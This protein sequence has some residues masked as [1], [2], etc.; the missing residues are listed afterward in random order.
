MLQVVI[1]INAVCFYSAFEQLPFWVVRWVFSLCFCVFLLITYYLCLVAFTGSPLHL[2]EQRIPYF[3]P[4]AEDS[5][6]LNSLSG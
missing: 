3:V 5:S 6:H 4:V 2:K 1:I